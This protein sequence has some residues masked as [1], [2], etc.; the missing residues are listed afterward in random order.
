M[1]I[2]AKSSSL[3]GVNMVLEG[4]EGLGAP[5]AAADAPNGSLPKTCQRIGAHPAAA[6]AAIAVMT[7]R[8]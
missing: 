5:S 1:Q 8:Q 2:R 4:P 3:G 7:E 6:V